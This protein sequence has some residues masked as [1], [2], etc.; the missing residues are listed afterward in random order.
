MARTAAS[1]NN[2]ASEL[3]I[4]AWRTLEKELRDLETPLLGRVMP[5]EKFQKLAESNPTTPKERKA[6][7]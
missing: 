2:D 1:Q 3:T 6:C 7:T 5:I 4:Q